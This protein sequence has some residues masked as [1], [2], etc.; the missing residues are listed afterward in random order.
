MGMN[1]QGSP[2]G[3]PMPSGQPFMSTNSSY[4]IPVSQNYPNHPMQPGYSQP[5]PNVN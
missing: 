4:Q 5:N 3:Y 2:P 1:P